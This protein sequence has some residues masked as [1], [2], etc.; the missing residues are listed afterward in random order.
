GYGD[1]PLV[2]ADADHNQVR[3]MVGRRVAGSLVGAVALT[4]YLQLGLDVPLILN[5]AGDNVMQPTSIDSFAL[6]D[7]RVIPKLQL[8]DVARHGIALAILPTITLPTSTTDAYA[9]E[10]GVSF[11]P[12]IAASRPFGPVRIIVDLGLRLREKATLHDLTVGNEVFLRAGAAYRLNPKLE[13]GATTSVASASGNF[14]G[15]VNVDHWEALG[16]AQYDVLPN[17]VAF[18]GAGVGLNHGFGTP[19]WRVLV[20]TR[21]H[22]ER[23]PKP[24]P[25]IVAV[26]PPPVEPAPEPEVVPPPP[27]QDSDGDG[28][29]DDQD[30]CPDQPGVASLQGC[31]EPDRDGDGVIDRLDNCPDEPG[32]AANQGCKQP[33]QVQLTGDKLEI[34]DVVYF[35]TNKWVLLKRSNALLDN[36]AQVLNAHPDLAIRVEGHTD[37]RGSATWNT[38]LSQHRAEA[39]VAYL[40]K[41]GVAKD[42]LQAQ[43]YGPTRPIAPNDTKENQA[44]NRRVDFVIVGNATGIQQQSSGPGTD[45]MDKK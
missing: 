17:L 7:L 18:A 27:P 10:G 35:E 40:V 5:Q 36:V 43:G 1:D 8:L 34:L 21:F 29:T 44:K 33:Q 41:K 26:T 14:F 42:R 6:G 32:D 13:L 28:I 24:V 37:D 22:V 39:V 30:K 4:N 25:A 9:G 2:L 19:D 38:T 20:G 31:P 11:Q 16:G 12:E 45:T 3:S 15:R 23:Q